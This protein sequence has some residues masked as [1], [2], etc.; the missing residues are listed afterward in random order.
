MATKLTN[1]KTAIILHAVI[2]LA[3]SE[4]QKI[5][6]DER[7]AVRRQMKLDKQSLVFMV[8]LPIRSKPLS[9]H[10]NHL[11]RSSHLR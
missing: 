5:I 6:N 10:G 3:A 11:C 2:D 4:K 7:R 1:K 9:N 8:C